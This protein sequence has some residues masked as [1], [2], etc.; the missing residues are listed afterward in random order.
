M[1]INISI[2]DITVHP[3]SNSE[4][5]DRAFEILKV[6]PEAKFTLFIPTA[7]RRQGEQSYRLSEYPD[8]CKTI[9][10]LPTANFELCW[11][12]HN[13]GIK[14]VSSN[15]EFIYLDYTE[16]LAHYK[17]MFEEA[18]KAGLFELYKPVF[19]PP[20]WKLSPKAFRAAWDCGIKILSLSPKSYAQ[21]SYKD[22]HKDW[23][24]KIIFYNV[25]PPFDDLKLYAETVCVYHACQWDKNYMDK[26]KTQE[27]I[28]FIQEN[29]EML[30]PCFFE[31]LV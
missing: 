20:A 28:A 26:A 24:G 16:S 19:R 14:N 12:G 11:H 22:A 31:D 15:S 9:K 29:K 18:E 23:P 1:K 7:Y 21:E 17:A 27:L 25:N 2:D 5:L 30:T 8:F 10:D 3:K 6:W 4:V 13:H